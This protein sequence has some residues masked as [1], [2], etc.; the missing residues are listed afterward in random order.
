VL[1]VAALGAAQQPGSDE[2]RVSSQPYV[3]QAPYTFRVESAL[4]EVGVA[5]RDGHGRAVGGLKREDF[6]IYDDGKERVIGSFSENRAAAEALGAARPGTAS[7]QSAALETAAPERRAAP[8]AAL[9]ARFLALLFDDVNIPNSESAGDL[10]RAQ[11]AATQFVKVHIQAGVRAGVFTTSGS[12]TLDFTADTAKLVEAIAELKPHA[13]LSDMACPFI[14]PYQAF[15]IAQNRDPE[16]IRNA[17]FEAAQRRCPTSRNAIITQAEEMWR[18][19]KAISMDTLGSIA[20]VLNRLAAMPGE[21]VLVL[22][23]SGFAGQTLEPQQDRIIDQAVRAGVTINALVTKGLYNE[24]LPGERFSDPQPERGIFTFVP[25]YQRF[26]KSEIDELGERP[27]VM[28]WAMANLARGTGGVLFENN[29]DLNTGFRQ[30]SVPPEVSYRMS[31]SPE[32][33]IGDGSY[34]ELKVKLAHSASYS[35]EARPGYYAQEAPASEK[36]RARID[37]EVRASDALAGIAAGVALE[38]AKLSEN[39]RTLRVRVHVEV[40]QLPFAEQNGRRVQRLTFVAAF[41]DAQGKMATAKEGRM[42][43]ALMP[44]TYERLARSGVNAELNFQV[45]PGVYRL[46]AVVGEGVNGALAA[47]TYP[48]EVR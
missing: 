30:V 13:R 18:L 35:V 32:G 43:L 44:A 20:S 1:A 29:N 2:I 27:Q 42:D 22:A 39:E 41:F 23:S 10:K 45:A 17:Q 47:A 48:I 31:F 11:S 46:R 6:R 3:A 9:R 8:A 7:P 26:I 36:L 33:V 40:G 24:L 19:T 14:S 12:Q 21:R 37:S 4:V 15:R 28:D 34:H 38:T 25:W 5:V 16:T